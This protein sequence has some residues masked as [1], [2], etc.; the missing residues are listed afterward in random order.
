MTFLL[1][2]EQLTVEEKISLLS[3]IEALNALTLVSDTVQKYSKKGKEFF[4]KTTA[5]MAGRV[6]ENT[7][8]KI[9]D[10]NNN[11][12]WDAEVL[13]RK[14]QEKYKYFSSLNKNELNDILLNKMKSIAD[15][16][17]K[18]END[19]LANGIVHR[20][21]KSLNI[22][23]RLYLNNLLL[24]NAVFEECIKEQIEM[25]KN[26]L[27]LSYQNYHP[28]NKKQLSRRSK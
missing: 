26:C 17:S 9:S 14:I 6:S 20:A 18:V 7:G 12:D 13:Q 1:G 10:F 4:L 2:F 23:V 24:E 21:A 8:K 25:L 28:L 15:F 27:T 3:Q 5:K 19:V 11:T 16:K 22:D